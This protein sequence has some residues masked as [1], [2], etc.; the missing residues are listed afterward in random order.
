MKRKVLLFTSDGMT[1]PASRIRGYLVARYLS[2]NGFDTRIFMYESTKTNIFMRSLHIINDFL[3]KINVVMKSGKEDLIYIQRGINSLSQ[4]SFIFFL[5]S[6]FIL[7]KKVIYDIDDALFLKEP[8]IINKLIR[9]SDLVIVGGHEL[10]NYAKKYNENVALIPTSVD[11]KR[12]SLNAFRKGDH[13][14]LGFVGSPSTTNYL[15]LLLNPLGKLAKRYDFELR[16]IS[17]PS[18]EGYKLF[19]HLFKNLERKGV[20]VKLIP[21]SIQGE[22]HE[23]QNIDIGL[24]P[25]FDGE[26]EKYKGGFKVIN[27]MAAGIPPVASDVG[28]HKHIIKDGINGFLC[29]NDQEWFEKLKKLIEDENLRE[30][31]GM[32]ARKTAEEKY[33]IEKNA[34][35]LARILFEMG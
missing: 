3:I 22:F 14:R 5:F 32:N 4:F 16:V 31:M 13:V 8:F 34:K 19:N 33:S 12:Y 23:L 29:K 20:K 15:R 27:Y 26:W 10:F 2:E 9:L 11:L 30:K 21:W 17:S 25:L 7:G 24:A 6:K 28:E 35:K 1:D 18:Y